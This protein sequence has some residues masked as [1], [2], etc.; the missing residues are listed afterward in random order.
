[1]PIILSWTSIA[2][3][4]KA[5]LIQRVRDQNFANKYV[6]IIYVWDNPASATYVRMKQKF[7]HDIGLPLKII[8]QQWEIKTHEDLMDVIVELSYDDDCLGFMP[9]LPL[10]SE[11]RPYMMELFDAIPPYKDIDGLGSAFIGQYITEQIDF[12]WATPQAVL[13]LLDHYGY[14]D[15]N[16]KIVSIVWQ[17]NLLGK[18]LALACMR[19]GATVMIFNS[20]SPDEQVKQSCLS[21]DIIISCTGVVHRLDESYFRSDQSQVVIDVG[22]GNLDGKPVGDVTLDT[23]AD[24]VAAYTPIPWGVWP[25]TIANLLMNVKR[26]Y[27]KYQ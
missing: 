2:N 18:P 23:I 26:L 10:T 5:E 21:S 9:Q 19:R 20:H 1:M 25:L 13:S 27:D 8:G 22:Y 24:K 3:Q 15:L 14:G 6:A 11:L 17:S 16:G 12:L 4:M 7:A